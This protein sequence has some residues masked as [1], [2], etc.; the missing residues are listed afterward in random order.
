V[1]AGRGGRPRG[2]AVDV[3]VYHEPGG[4]AG[5]GGAEVATAV[6]AHALR[7]RHAVE[8][9][10]HI[11]DLTAARLGEFARVDL[12]GVA[13]RTV[14]HPPHRGWVPPGAG[15]WN[16]GRALRGWKA[17]LSRGCDLFVTCTH[18]VPPINAAP[19]GMAY[20]HFPLYDRTREWPWAGAGRG[21][22]RVKGWLR[23]AAH[24]RYWRER[25]EGYQVVVGNSA[26]VA[27]HTR[28]RW[29]VPCGVLYPP[30]EVDRPHGPKG[31]VI[32]VLGRF[33]PMKAQAEIVRA[34]RGRERTDL[35]GWELVC[36]GTVGAGDDGY[37]REVREAAAGGAVTLLPD[38]P[39]EAVRDLLA[40]AAVF[41]H[42]A[43]LGVDPAAE[44]HRLEHFGIATVEAMAAGCV[45]V[46]LDRGGQREIVRHGAD[47]FLCGGLDEMADRV[48]ELAR[49][50]GLRGALGAA[51]RASARRFGRDR[52]VERV[53]AELA[54]LT[55]GGT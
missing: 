25:W 29:G 13:V 6:L 46:T 32:A 16:L 27:E 10:C 26:F 35:Q 36:A 4:T 45:P 48:A 15:V 43:G 38:A 44:P 37:F 11:P 2:L 50:D 9:V 5:L 30:V 28:A 34:F 20:V 47:G 18:G 41:W 42:A 17:D 39:A 12:G 53:R 1:A 8:V 31:K 33:T 51:A 54:P 19:A 52:F 3:T 14:P 7:D 49:D 23:R 21:V 40:R 22:G 55:G 24:D